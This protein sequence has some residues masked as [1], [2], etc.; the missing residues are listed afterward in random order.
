MRVEQLSAVT[1]C[2]NP[3]NKWP[4]HNSSTCTYCNGGTELDNLKKAVR[5]AYL[6]LGFYAA[7]YNYSTESAVTYPDGSVMKGILRDGGEQAREASE[8]IKIFLPDLEE[9]IK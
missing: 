9:I 8:K 6:T 7:P 1:R 2:S 5:Y 4:D 3:N